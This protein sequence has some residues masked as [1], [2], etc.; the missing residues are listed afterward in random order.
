MPC[1]APEQAGHIDT[2]LGGEEQRPKPITG[3][4][5]F[6]GNSVG[7]KLGPFQSS[8]GQIQV[9]KAGKDSGKEGPMAS[10]KMEQEK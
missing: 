2:H 8:L 5:S 6:K 1:S 9:N 4:P 10:S 3:H 7:T